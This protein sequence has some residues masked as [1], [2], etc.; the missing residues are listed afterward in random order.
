MSGNFFSKY[1]SQKWTETTVWRGSG[2][3]DRL[4]LATWAGWA[5][6]SNVGEGG[7]KDLSWGGRAL[8]G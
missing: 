2:G 3:L 1:R 8:L 6:T 5:A 7:P 4:A